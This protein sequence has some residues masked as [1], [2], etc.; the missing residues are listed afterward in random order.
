VLAPNGAHVGSALARRRYSAETADVSPVEGTIASR[1]HW[2]FFG[3]PRNRI[4]EAD[5]SIPSFSEVLRWSP[6][7]DAS[8]FR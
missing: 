2:F 4:E 5:G 7:H 6:P 8:R 3:S 1:N